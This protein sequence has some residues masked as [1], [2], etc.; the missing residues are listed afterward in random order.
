MAALAGVLA[1]SPTGRAETAAISAN[2]SAYALDNWPGHASDLGAS[3]SGELVTHW[4]VAAASRNLAGSHAGR[5]S[6][7][8]YHR[9]HI[10]GGAVAGGQVTSDQ[11]HPREVWNAWLVSRTLLSIA[12]PDGV[13]VDPGALRVFAPLEIDTYTVEL[14]EEGPPSIEGEV[15]FTWSGDTPS[16]T[17]TVSGSRLLAW[18]WPPDWSSGILDRLEWKTDVLPLA[19][20]A[21]QRIDL[22]IG[23]RRLYEFT[24]G[25]E[26]VARQHLEAALYGAGS[27]VWSVPLWHDAQDLAADLPAGSALIPLDTAGRQF[28]VGGSALLLG[29]TTAERESVSIA[30][31]DEAGLVLDGVTV[32]AWPAGTRVAPA[33]EAILTDTQRLTRFT[34]QA[35]APA[36]FR[37]EFLEPWDGTPAT[38][39]TYRGHPVVDTRPDW[40]RG[41]ELSLS[42][43]LEQ[44]DAMVGGWTSDDRTGL[45]LAAQTHGW[46]LTDREAIAAHYARLALLRG[47]LTA[48][49]VP[50]FTDD[51]T[52]QEPAAAGAAT[53][54]VAWCGYTQHLLGE[55]GRQ[56]VRLQLLDGTVAFARIVDAVELDADTEQLTLEDDLGVDVDPADVAFISYMTL[57]RQQSDAAEIAYWTGDV[58]GATTTWQSFRNDV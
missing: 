1:A 44:L 55:I 28:V 6:D 9:I 58:A 51:L 20:G 13:T 36:R 38:L 18:T 25:A 10:L 39:D 57:C 42:R 4:P 8:Y 7:D 35:N 31:V 54:V 40:S 19:D 26:G 3:P 32:S 49:W 50:T 47:R 29:R 5:Y 34:G 2:L 24:V 16:P 21:E 56:D 27:R 23:A 11:E 14:A 52:L 48:A 12:A 46:T 41:L 37:F 30:A 45:P 15:V 53:L 33:Y 43:D 22:R 17:I